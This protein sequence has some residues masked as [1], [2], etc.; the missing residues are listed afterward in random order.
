M[1]LV[2]LEQEVEALRKEV[3]RLQEEV[4]ALHQAR[5]A[6]KHPVEVLLWQRGLPVL[7]HGDRTQVLLPANPSFSQTDLFYRLMRRYSFRLFLRELLQIPEGREASFLSRYC[8]EKTAKTYLENLSDLDVVRLHPDGSYEV[9]KRHVVSFGPTLEWYVSEIFQKEFLA[10]A[11]FNVRLRN[12]QY[13]GDYDVITLLGEVLVYGEVKSSPPRGIELPAVAAFLDRLQDLQPHM[14]VF[15]VDTELRMLDK[16]VP[17][18]AEA[19]EKQ[20]HF[21]DQWPVIRLVNELFHIRHSI[22]IVNS[23]NGIY[24]NLRLCLRDFLRYRGKAK[25]P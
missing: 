14:A 8:S 11:L 18:F 20:G 25:I 4:K 15:L 9:V 10:P 24:T 2:Q 6:E 3:S 16:M 22:Y 13:G 7:D 17:L 23:R 19:L 12:T 21:P 5:M 1:N